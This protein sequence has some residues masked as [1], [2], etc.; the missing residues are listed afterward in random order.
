MK[1]AAT[2]VLSLLALLL[3]CGALISPR[4]ATAG[5]AEMAPAPSAAAESAAPTPTPVPTPAP[6]PTPTPEPTPSVARLLFGGDL[7]IHTSLTDDAAQADGSY[8]FA[9]MFEDVQE[10]ISSADYATCCLEAALTGEPPWTGYPLFH[11]PDGI[12]Y[13]LAE[14]GF[15]LV[16]TASNH[17]VDGRLAGIVRTLDVLDE[18]GLDHVGTY[19]TQEERDENSGILV[20]EINGITVA[21]LDFTYGTNAI[22][23]DDYPYAVNVY[24]LDY[25]TTLVDVDYEML[26]ADMAAA[27]ALDT[28]VIIVT[29]HWGAE[30]LTG[31]T[32]YQR[33]LADYLFAQGADIV[34]GGHPH[35]PE[36]MEL[37]R[38]TDENGAERTCFLVYSLGNLL[39]GQDRTY[40]DLTA[41]VSIELTKDPYTGE[42]EITA[43]GYT[44]MIMVDL[45]DY[46]VTDQGWR[47][48]LW[49]L[50]RAIADYESGDDRGVITPGMYNAFV[51]ALDDCE[52]IFG[53]LEF[54]AEEDAA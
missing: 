9:P 19:R 51:T 10:L 47:C 41:M 27:R 5:I 8:D 21:F 48:R 11:L 12:A 45:Y 16:N 30:Y 36:P 24:N 29:V 35:V 15:D 46:G 28:D 25:M 54:P 6:T 52:R 20:K 33:S 23:V 18:A 31:P 14:V 32:Q 53:T 39:S 4:A 17:A 38:V 26:D 40:T 37:R 44:P 43:A 1:K 34:I 50:R 2:P 3:V 13:S 22:P 7:V 42:T 49:D